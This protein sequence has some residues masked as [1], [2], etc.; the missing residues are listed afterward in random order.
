M[1]VKQKIIKNREENHKNRYNLQFNH[2]EPSHVASK[3]KLAIT[4]S[5]ENCLNELNTKKSK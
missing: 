4:D 1:N 3:S 5:K 2:A